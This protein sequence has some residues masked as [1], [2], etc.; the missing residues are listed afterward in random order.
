MLIKNIKAFDFEGDNDYFGPNSEDESIGSTCTNVDPNTPTPVDPTQNFGITTARPEEDQTDIN[1]RSSGANINDDPVN[2]SNAQRTGYDPS[3]FYPPNDSSTSQYRLLDTSDT[4]FGSTLSDLSQIKSDALQYFNNES[5]FM[6]LMTGK[7]KVSDFVPGENV[8]MAGLE[9]GLLTSAIGF[10]IGFAICGPP[11]ALELMDLSFEPGFNAGSA[12][13]NT[14]DE[15]LDKGYALDSIFN[16]FRSQ[17][18]DSLPLANIPNPQPGP[19][20]DLIL[21][22][23]ILK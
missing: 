13:H 3:S 16:N 5:A 8:L 12:V 10:G 14:W 20:P 17:Q 6:I 18:M 9:T 21:S 2:V 7:D 15:F 22:K 4:N 19:T 23:Q 11:C 1:D